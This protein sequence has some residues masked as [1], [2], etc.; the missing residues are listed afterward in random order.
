MAKWST[1]KNAFLAIACFYLFIIV[2][3]GAVDQVNEAHQEVGKWVRLEIIISQETG[4]G[5]F[6]ATTDDVIVGRY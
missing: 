3:V 4:S 6:V 5:R 2:S 1:P